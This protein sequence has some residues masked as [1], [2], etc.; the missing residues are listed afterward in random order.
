MVLRT[1]YLD[2]DPYGLH[3]CLVTY[4]C[5]LYVDPYELHSYLATYK[6]HH[7]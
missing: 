7:L 6:F 1:L 5:H 2:I 3:Q 4:G